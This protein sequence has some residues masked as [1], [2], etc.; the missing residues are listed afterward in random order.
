MALNGKGFAL[1]SGILRGLP[2]FAITLVAAAGGIGNNV[3][4]I[5]AV[6]TYLGSVIGLI[7]GFVSGLVAGG[8]L[9]S[10]CNRFASPK[11]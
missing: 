2:L 6:F 10:V 11:T 5:L 8:L 4:H 1:T 7:Y 3:S 9:A